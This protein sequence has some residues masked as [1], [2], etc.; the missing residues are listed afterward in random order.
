MQRGVFNE[1]DSSQQLGG[2]WIIIISWMP[3]LMMM[4][5]ARAKKLFLTVD[6]R[7]H[8]LRHNSHLVSAIAQHGSQINDFLFFKKIR[9]F[10][11]SLR[12]FGKS[13]CMSRNK[14]WNG[15]KS[16]KL[17][18]SLTLK[19]SNCCERIFCEWRW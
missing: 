7:L 2:T 8:S 15:V 16:A 18:A 17:L 3:L 6:V 1:L 13:N 12:V 9:G 11:P 10:F 5:A 14:Y 4:N 19:H